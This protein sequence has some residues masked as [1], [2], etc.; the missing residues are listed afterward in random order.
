MD[1]PEDAEL[2]LQR[3]SADLLSEFSLLLPRFLWPTP[4]VGQQ[5]EGKEG[6]LFARKVVKERSTE[7][8]INLV[9]PTSDAIGGVHNYVTCTDS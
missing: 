5:N 7:Q 9:C 4:K 2:H 3:A 1:A 6:P 8:L